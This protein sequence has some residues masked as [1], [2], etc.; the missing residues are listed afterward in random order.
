MLLYNLWVVATSVGRLSVAVVKIGCNV[1]AWVVPRMF[2]NG[3]RDPTQV[4]TFG[5]PVGLVVVSSVVAILL[6]SV[7]TLDF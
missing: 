7:D 6:N 3:S 2:R 5:V 4:R 1:W